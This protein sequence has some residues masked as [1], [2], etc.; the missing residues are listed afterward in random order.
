M[1][2]LMPT[3]TTLTQELVPKEDI[4]SATASINLFRSLGATIGVSVLGAVLNNR[5][6]T[7]LQA[8]IDENPEY[9]SALS[10]NIQELLRNGSGLSPEVYSDL[11]NLFIDS[12][13]VLF[14]LSAALLAVAVFASLFVGNGKLATQNPN[15]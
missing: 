10:L 1:G 12:L 7:N 6:A 3:L 13:N 4:G 8:T 2:M 15:D 9:A 11:L 5:L 14:V